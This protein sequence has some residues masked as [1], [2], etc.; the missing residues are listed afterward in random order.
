M[1]YNGGSESNRKSFEMQRFKTKPYDHQLEAFN[2]SCE[3]ESF[4]LLM[5]QGTGKTKVIIDTAAHLFGLG[6]IDAVLVVAPNGVHRNW[7]HNELP[8]HHPDWAPHIATYWSST[9][10]KAEKSALEN[11]LDPK[12]V[13]LRWLS[14]NVEAFSSE[15]G[16]K[17]A[18]NWL[19]THKVLFVIDES[20][21]IKTPTAQRTKNILKLAKLAPYRRIMTG[22]PVTQG[23][24]DVFAQFSFLD[25]NILKT[26]S[27]Y[28]F[29]AEYSELLPANHGLMRHITARTGSKFVP[30]V[31]AKDKNG[32]PIWKNLDKLQSLLAPYSYRKRK[33]E[34]LDLPPKIYQRLYHELE[35]VQE[36]AYK[37]IKD[38][39]RMKMESGDVKVLTKMESILRLQQVVGG[40]DGEGNSYFETPEKNPRIAALLE[41]L[42][43]IQGGVIIWARFVAEIK[44][45][46]AALKA[47]YGDDSVVQYFGEVKQQDRV[48]AVD[49]FQASDARFFVGQPHSGG[50]GLTLTKAK[51]V[52]YYSNDYSLETRLQSEDRAHRIGQD[53]SV[54]YIDVEAVG[55]IDKAIVKALRDKQDIASLVTGDPKLEWI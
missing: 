33:V 19:R 49:K 4:A 55:T 51:T 52:I 41:A 14:L 38:E 31:I 40:H 37:L 47:K 43:E 16:R 22:T 3:L 12:F 23:P 13:G 39:L 10:T 11:L 7:I 9:P 24:T 54:T 6:R 35:P 27:F 50:I 21:R 46:S 18:E 28:A 2:L 20:S 36:K 26:S 8:T 34:C 32:R 15:K 42:E 53:E 30:Q 1:G 25:E 5:E 48:D 44:A 29:K 45:I 17:M